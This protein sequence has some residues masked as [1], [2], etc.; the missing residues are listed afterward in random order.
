MFFLCI[1]CY[2]FYS[3]IL[4]VKQNNDILPVPPNILPFSFGEK[5]ANV[6]EYLQAACTVN[7]GDLPL[8]I[9]WMFNGHLISQRNNDYSMTHSKRSS[10]LI[11][12]SV[13]AKHAGSYT[14]I[15]ENR[16]GR[17]TYSAELIVYG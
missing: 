12:E 5:P 1:L 10:L 13:D 6:G 4:L 2:L 7:F 17:T 11:I 15:G 8:T 16:A 3:Y 9:T 14:C